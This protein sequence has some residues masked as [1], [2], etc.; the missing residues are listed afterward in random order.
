MFAVGAPASVSLST[1]LSALFAQPTDR[2][3]ERDLAVGESVVRACVCVRVL[4][5]AA[6]LAP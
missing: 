4:V 6:I 1:G 2:G 3:Y 5:A